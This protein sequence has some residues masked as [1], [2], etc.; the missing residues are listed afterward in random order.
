MLRNIDSKFL[1]VGNKENK[2]SKATELHEQEDEMLMRAIAL[3]LEV[4]EIKGHVSITQSESGV[5]DLSKLPQC[6]LFMP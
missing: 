1:I 6:P 5:F 2:S 4:N 3:S